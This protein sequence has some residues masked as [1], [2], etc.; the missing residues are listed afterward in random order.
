[1]VISVNES[2]QVGDARRG[3]ALL[4]E[5]LGFNEVD[6]GKVGIVVTEAA[7]NLVKHAGGGKVIL[8]PLSDAARR[9]LE[10]LTLDQG[11]GMRDI[12]KCLTDGYSTAGSPGTGLGAIQ[13]L[14]T[15]FDIFSEAGNGTVLLA[16][17]FAKGSAPAGEHLTVGAICTPHTEREPCGDAWS[18]RDLPGRSQVLL[19]DGLGHGLLAARAAAQAVESFQELVGR[20]TTEIV[21]GLHGP[22]RS[23]RGA[24]LAIAEMDF[25]A[26]IVRYSGVGNIAAAICQAEA[27]RSLISQNGTVGHEL[28]RVTEFSYP[29]PAGATLVM[30]SDGLTSRWKLSAYPGLLHRHPSI[31]AGLLFRDFQRGRDDV[32]VLALR[33][34]HAEK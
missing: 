16:Q 23:T 13:R 15:V 7:N 9:G 11:P 22:L 25:S 26:N 20:P 30:H 24:S 21:Q 34:N 29:W 5:E 17:I 32:T 12:A 28:H 1:M 3:A 27:A 4:V 8:R 10:I 31:V 19:V 14:S 33:Q 6:A 18:V 2:S